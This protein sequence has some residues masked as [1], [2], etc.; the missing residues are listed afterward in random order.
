[1]KRARVVQWGLI[2]A[3]LIVLT[4]I[5]LFP[6]R[7]GL[8][9]Y[10]APVQSLQILQDPMWFVIALTLFVGLTLLYL[11]YFGGSPS[12]LN[13]L[14][15][16]CFAAV[17]IGYWI[18]AA[19]FQRGEGLRLLTQTIAYQREGTFN[20][21]ARNGN[22]GYLDFPGLFLIAQFLLNATGLN[23]M[24]VPQL[25]LWSIALTFPVLLYLTFKNFLKD[26]QSAL[27]AVLLLVIGGLYDV[28]QFYFHPD[29]LGLY[30]VALSI[31][32][33][34]RT[35]S[36][37]IGVEIPFFVFLAALVTNLMSAL[38]ILSL[39]GGLWSAAKFKFYINKKVSGACALSILHAREDGS[40]G[41]D[42][43][44]VQIYGP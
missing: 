7:Y 21:A 8:D 26:E 17:W 25:F 5:F 22:L 6:T 20:V 38:S 9:A 41:Y 30:F 24:A 44:H 23:I 14:L 43:M 18:F 39:A 13:L 40:K 28:A 31:L 19:P 42:N 32:I 11:W 34:S 36:G 10:V 27:L 3:I 12:M 4:V 33:L 37:K 35:R 29:A 16:V 2:F 15:P 1:M